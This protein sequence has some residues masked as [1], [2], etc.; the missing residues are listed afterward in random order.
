MA[1]SFDTWLGSLHNWLQTGAAD[2][3]A[4]QKPPSDGGVAALADL[5]VAEA[6]K[7]PAAFKAI[8]V[9]AF[10]APAAGVVVRLQRIGTVRGVNA[11]DPTASLDFG[12]ADIDVVYGHNG[13]G[14]S[15]FARL[16]KEAA[17][18]RARSTIHPNVFAPS[19]PEPQATFVVQHD[20]QDVNAVWK[21]A[22]GSVAQLRNLHVFDREVALSYVNDKA[23][24]RYEP[25]RL[26]FI[27][28]L[29]DLSDRVRDELQRRVSALPSTLPAI[30]VSLIGTPLANVV[31]S[32]K[33]S[34]SDDDLRKKVQRAANHA[35]RT[36]ELE[37]ALKAPDPA[38]RIKA[39][40]TT[41]SDI[42]ALT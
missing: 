9:G 14:K 2:L 10:D 8:P 16:T 32:L 38:A 42:E 41:I 7:E 26:R 29:S 25:R 31:S 23:E 39:I 3:L 15:S 35:E 27:T 12:D 37:D 22:S 13:T 6:K 34:M 36:Q 19:S 11:L 28:A 18:G 30:P 33:P 5:C 17:A 21:Q 4:N 1:D 40:E 24:A 20:G